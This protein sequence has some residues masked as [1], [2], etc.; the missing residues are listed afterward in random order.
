M[1]KCVVY[2]SGYGSVEMAFELGTSEKEKDE[3]PKIKSIVLP[4]QNSSQ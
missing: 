3:P 1:V 4:S 2:G